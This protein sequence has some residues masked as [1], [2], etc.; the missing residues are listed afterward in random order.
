[1]DPTSAHR[2]IELQV[3]EDLT[4]LINNVRHAAHERIDEAFPPASQSRGEEDQ[5]RS[6]IEALVNDFIAKTFTLASPSLTI[7][8]LPIDPAPFLGAN[9]SS[10]ASPA[11]TDV[12]YEPF[13]HKLHDRVFD[14]ARQEE[15]LLSEI[16]RLKTQ[17]PRDV[18]SAFGDGMVEGIRAD[19]AAVEDAKQRVS[20]PSEADGKLASVG[21]GERRQLPER[22]ASATQSLARLQME[23]PA[24]VA[25]MERARVAGEYVI[26]Q[27][28]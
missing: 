26:T 14:L 1:M 16:A 3:P 23:M 4:Y 2:K 9:P 18:A 10:S 11:A 8:G 7:N 12:A 27:G 24:A 6:Q 22:L 28:R 21:A 17:V 20:V 13:N 19:D 25:K 5:L 15:D